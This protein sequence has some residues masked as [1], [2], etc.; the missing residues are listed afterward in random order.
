MIRLYIY[1]EGQTEERFVNELLSSYLLRSNISVIPIIA[2]TK[3]TPTKKYKGGVSSYK[4]I[5]DEINILCKGDK[6]SFVTT[7][8]DY[9]GLPTD[10]PGR[11]NPIGKD[12]YEKVSYV[13]SQMTLDMGLDNFIP[14]I[15]LHEFEG[16]L[17][18]KPECFSYCDSNIRKVDKIIKIRK[19]YES[20]EHINDGVNT[21]PSKRVKKIFDNY[22]KV[23]DGINI[24]IDIGIHEILNECHHFRQ[25]VDKLMKLTSD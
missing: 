22:D 20:P 19:D 7:M 15:L 17:F 21:A 13:E 9:Y 10:V 23:I 2:A 4:K 6:T 12:I 24:A 16:L 11:E 25:W 3:R 5:K 8:L 18:S 1:C 14:N